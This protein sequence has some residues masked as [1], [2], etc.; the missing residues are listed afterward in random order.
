MFSEAAISATAD[1]LT[2]AQRELLLNLA[3]PVA[4]GVYFSSVSDEQVLLDAGLI[5]GIDSVEVS[6]VTPLGRIIATRIRET[7]ANNG[8]VLAM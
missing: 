5:S 7:D 2:A 8:N 1:A 6:D 3:Y 4:F